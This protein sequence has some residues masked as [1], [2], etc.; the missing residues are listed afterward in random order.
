M[1]MLLVSGDFS[2]GWCAAD[3]RKRDLKK[4][5]VVYEVSWQMATEFLI[6]GRLQKC[7]CQWKARIRG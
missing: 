2:G 5:A 4:P 7:L 6:P 3:A 1:T